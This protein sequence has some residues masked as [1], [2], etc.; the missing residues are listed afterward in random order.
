VALSQL[1]TGKHHGGKVKQWAFET[2]T[3]CRNKMS[4]GAKREKIRRNKEDR[5]ALFLLLRELARG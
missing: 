2:H 1:Q 5:V 3:E 4:S